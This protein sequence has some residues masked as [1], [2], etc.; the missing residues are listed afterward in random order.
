MQTYFS[1]FDKFMKTIWKAENG[2]V[3]ESRTILQP[4]VSKD[5]GASLNPF[6]FS[7]SLYP[8]NN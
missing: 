1:L 4:N 6:N 3:K 7:V 5:D 8:F 2:W